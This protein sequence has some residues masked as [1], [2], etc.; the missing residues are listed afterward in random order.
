MVS[1]LGYSGPMRTTTIRSSDTS[2]QLDRFSIAARSK[3][4]FQASDG[5]LKNSLSSNYLKAFD[6]FMLSSPVMA[7]DPKVIAYA[8][9]GNPPQNNGGYLT[10]GDPRTVKH[11]LTITPG[12]TV[13]IL[14]TNKQ[15]KTVT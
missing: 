5:K 12:V 6:D 2:K 14:K 9:L 10:S 3:Q 1:N 4:M 8:T 7:L 11:A 15:D 13:S